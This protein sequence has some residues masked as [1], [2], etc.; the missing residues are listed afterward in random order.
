MFNSGGNMNN[1]VKTLLMVGSLIVASSCAIQVGAHDSNG[2]DVDSVFGGIEID[3]GSTV[4]DVSSVNGGIDIESGATARNV[5]T[6]NGGIVLGNNVTIVSA[7]T[8]NGG[9]N[10]G[11]DL[12]VTKGLETVNG[13]I[14]VAQGGNVGGNIETING[15]IELIQV[16]VEKNLKTIN[17]DITLAES[18]VVK[19]DLVIEKSGGW[20]SSVT[21]DKITISIDKSS[22]VLGTIHLYKEVNLKISEGAEIGQI[23]THYL[24]E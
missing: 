20:F 12:S 10:A 6:V 11:N 22:A 13:G 19:G 14:Y 9:I 23:E 5:E 7:E 16:I 3:S 8:V 4:R 17:G 2:K 21:G 15:D 18:S 1:L 24:R